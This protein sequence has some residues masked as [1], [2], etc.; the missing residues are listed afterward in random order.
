MQHFPIR[1]LSI[2]SMVLGMLVL[3][4]A[5]T[6]GQRAGSAAR[7]GG[8][9]PE[10][11]PLERKESEAQP[12]PSPG[13]LAT[14]GAEANLPGGAGSPTPTP[15]P[16]PFCDNTEPGKC[17][18]TFS[19]TYGLLVSARPRHEEGTSQKT[20]GGFA[21]NVYVTRRVFV[22]VD[23]DNFVSLKPGRAD[24]RTGRGD[25]V[26]ILGGDALL[27]KEGSKRPAVYAF[28]GIKIPTGDSKKAVSSGKVD[29]FAVAA[30]DKTL[31]RTYLELDFSEYFSGRSSSHGFDKSSS[32]SGI[33]ERTLGAE[34]KNTLHLEVGGTFATRETNA[35]I[36]NLSYFEHLLNERIAIRIGGRFGIT[37]NVPRAALYVAV[38]LKG[39]LKELVK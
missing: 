17:P 12:S 19:L 22:E 5:S 20:V 27:E 34:E 38:K 32:L 26:L 31:G 18:G 4:S 33:L 8:A 30:V 29:H 36:Y 14:G 9:R 10:R 35:E 1:I 25:T 24:R 13:T 11:P 3:C 23:N 15:E 2:A 28:Y 39:N 37:P 7:G 21:F 16:T 6:S